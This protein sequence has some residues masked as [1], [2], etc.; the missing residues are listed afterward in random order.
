MALQSDF[1]ADTPSGSGD[2]DFFASNK[3]FDRLGIE[4]FGMTREKLF[5]LEAKGRAYL[6]FP[7]AMTISNTE[8]RRDRLEAAY[9]AGTAQIRREMPAIK[10]FLGL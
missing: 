2:E 10:E 4:V 5:D 3:G 9:R 1:T 7:E 8:M 6:F